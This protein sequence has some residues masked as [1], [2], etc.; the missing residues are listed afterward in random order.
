MKI[1]IEVAL[2][3]ENK[4]CLFV[5]S[6]F[7][8][9][10]VQRRSVAVLCMLQKIKCNLMHPLYGAL[11]VPYVSVRLHP[12]AV[13]ART[14]VHLYAPPRCRTPQYRRTYIQLSVSLE[15]S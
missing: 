5:F 14:S 4:V 3:V 1:L 2:L 7:E 9:D 8:C 6:V 15:R 10:L 11:P 12:A 13:I